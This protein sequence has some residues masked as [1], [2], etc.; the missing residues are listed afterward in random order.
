MPDPAG[1]GPSAASLAPARPAETRSGS[2][3]A[4]E[5]LT[6]GMDAAA[7]HEQG[8]DKAAGGGAALPALLGGAVRTW[9]RYDERIGAHEAAPPLPP[10]PAPHAWP[11]PAEATG[12][13]W[14]PDG[15][16]DA[17]AGG[18]RPQS[19][20]ADRPPG[21]PPQLD[22]P[23]GGVAR[24]WDV[25]SGSSVSIPGAGDAVWGSAG[26]GGA[27]WGA[28]PDAAAEPES[29]PP[30]A[31]AAA[32]AA[33]ASPRF[34]G[35]PAAPAADALALP[36][37]QD[38][39]VKRGEVERVP[40]PLQAPAPAP[41]AS[42]TTA[43]HKPEPWA[44]A[45]QSGASWPDA[46]A[47]VEGSLD[48]YDA[49]AGAPTH[50]AAHGQGQRAEPP[51]EASTGQDAVA[52]ASEAPPADTHRA[53]AAAGASGEREPWAPWL[54]ARAGSGGWSALV[55]VPAGGQPEPASGAPGSR[56]LPPPAGD[57]QWDEEPPTGGARAEQRSTGGPGTG[58]SAIAQA[59]PS[60]HD[61]VQGGGGEPDSTAPAALTPAL[62][63]SDASS[64]SKPGSAASQA[65]HRAA[66]SGERAEAGIAGRPE[67]GAAAGGRPA[68]SGTDQA[69][70]GSADG[71]APVLPW[72]AASASSRRAAAAARTAP[73]APAGSGVGSGTISESSR[74]DVG[75]GRSKPLPEA[76]LRKQ[77]ANLERS[78]A[79]KCLHCLK[80]SHSCA[81]VRQAYLPVTRAA[82][83]YSRTAL[84]GPALRCWLPPCTARRL[85]RSSWRVLRPAWGAATCKH[86]LLLSQ[87]GRPALLASV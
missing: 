9:V 4:P 78:L 48:M 55:D 74:S 77:R 52:A 44:S 19:Q 71:G 68:A 32:D 62:G 14:R 75:S 21:P 37:V 49:D 12:Q 69:S 79:G 87:R 51:A 67:G 20:P 73:L 26:A 8:A 59:L 86:C 5:E 58:A 10:P 24:R 35:R 41:A 25:W 81:P 70:A 42:T 60:G 38:P 63:K 36:R 18:A 15:A 54:S 13:G 7:A 72:R 53:A 31:D 83:S 80:P 57:A 40:W 47:S 16:A 33:A 34:P 3:Q 43:D 65:A 30:P 61:G 39:V 11:E 6:S 46:S 64:A 45:A 28:A 23:E 17:G 66:E 22:L 76:E 82:L 50:A 1:G 84:G 56:P 27:A 29:R 85:G 2:G